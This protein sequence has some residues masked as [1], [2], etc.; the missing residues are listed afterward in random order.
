MP[1]RR[2]NQLNRMS[3]RL[4]RRLNRLVV[5]VRASRGNRGRHRYALMQAHAILNEYFE[6]LVAFTFNM[7]VKRDLHRRKDVKE[8]S[9]A[10]MQTLR[11]EVDRKLEDFKQILAD[12]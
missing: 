9:Y 10:D 2:Y 6:Q 5:W 12:V 3:E 8:L 11:L 7:H 4:A 1:K